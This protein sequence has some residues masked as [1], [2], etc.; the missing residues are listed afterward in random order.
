MRRSCAVMLASIGSEEK[1]VSC[2]VRHDPLFCKCSGVKKYEYKDNDVG[3]LGR[4]PVRVE[5]VWAVQPCTQHRAPETALDPCVLRLRAGAAHA[6]VPAAAADH[7]AGQARAWP[8]RAWA[9][10]WRLPRSRPPNY[11]PPA[12][13]GA[14]AVHP[15]ERSGLQR[16]VRAV[17]LA[18]TISAQIIWPPFH[19]LLHEAGT[20]LTAGCARAT[21]GMQ[22]HTSN[23]YIGC[24]ER[25]FCGHAGG[26]LTAG[27]ALAPSLR[28]RDLDPAGGGVHVGHRGARVAGGHRPGRAQ[29]RPGRGRGHDRQRQVLAAGG[30]PRPHA[31]GAR[32]A[33]Q[34]PRQGARLCLRP[35]QAC[36]PP[37]THR[38]VWF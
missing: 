9:S 24:S 32:A 30:R 16:L 15:P 37:F 1:Q 18:P 7:A 33:R 21:Q 35:D 20:A 3:K 2:L 31:A 10:S 38:K 6:A 17:R 19:P 12:E 5:F 26:A 11:L 36:H 27:C 23:A 28:R 13:T 4:L 22:Q 25:H 14:R 8:S 34:R 29:G